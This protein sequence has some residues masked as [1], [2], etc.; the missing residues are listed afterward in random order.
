MNGPVASFLL[1]AALL[2]CALADAVTA[3]AIW[4][5]STT[6]FS[7]VAGADP[8]LAQN[9]DMIS[10]HVAITRGDMG[11]LYNAVLESSYDKVGRT[12]PA[13]TEWATDINNPGQPVTATNWSALAYT[14]WSAAYG[15]HVGTTI[16]GRPAVAHLI[17]DDV[18]LNVLVTDWAGGESGG[19]FTYQRS[20]APAAGGDY[21][22]NGFV[23]A[24][25]YTI[26]RDTLGQT[27][28]LGT[29]ADGYVSGE[30]D[31][32]DYTMWKNNFGDSVPTAGRAAEIAEPVS[33]AIAAIGAPLIA[34]A[35]FYTARYGGQVTGQISS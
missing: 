25:D 12:A 9:Q 29:G 2:S 20:T 13:D 32:G 24:A 6:T 23:D 31:E 35:S 30:I 22:H 33:I 16:V 19:A 7:K 28:P 3:A 18:Y 4:T 10:S 1:P 15:D 14:T 26:W 11:G 27:V 8:T 17:T 21:N 34:S 5:G